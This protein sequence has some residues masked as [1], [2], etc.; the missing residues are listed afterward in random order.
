MW[1]AAA[2][3]GARGEHLLDGGGERSARGGGSAEQQGEDADDDRAHVDVPNWCS[4]RRKRRAP[5]RP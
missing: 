1:H 4:G 2:E 5:R 3:R